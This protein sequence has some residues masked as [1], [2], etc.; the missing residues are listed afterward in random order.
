LGRP[1]RPGRG[2]A[3][4]ALNAPAVTLRQYEQASHDA[5]EDFVVEV[6][7]V[8]TRRDARGRPRHEPCI[9]HVNQHGIRVIVVARSG[10]TKTCHHQ[11][12]GGCPRPV[13]QG[14]LA[15]M[16]QEK[17][18]NAVDAENETGHVVRWRGHE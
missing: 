3:R 11:H 7:Y 6:S 12:Y 9:G 5:W 2:R 4:G 8:N 14:Q 18:D 13:L 15:E 17:I 10:R 1:H 16:I